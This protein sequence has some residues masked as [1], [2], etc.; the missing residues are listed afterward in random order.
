MDNH[1]FFNE[2][3]NFFKSTLFLVNVL[4]GLGL[5]F[6][7][8]LGA[9]GQMIF[10]QNLPIL[11][12]Y[13]ISFIMEICWV[14]SSIIMVVRKE[15]PRPPFPSTRGTMAVI[16]GILGIIFWGGWSLFFLYSI[17]LELFF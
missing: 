13:F 15:M 11:Y 1:S 7:I 14:V 16:I 17:F 4:P 8:G 12:I 3:K 5:I 6:F 2:I 9:I 10:G